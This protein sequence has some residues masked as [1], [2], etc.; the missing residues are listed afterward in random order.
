MSRASRKV[1]VLGTRHSFNDVAAIDAQVDDAAVTQ[2]Q[3]ENS[4][5][6]YISL[7]QLNA[8]VEIDS[9]RSTVTCG[10][11]ITYGE[12]C[13]RMHMEGVALHNTAS[14][15]H[16]TV[17]GACATGTHG[18]GRRQRQPFDSRCRVGAGDGRWGTAFAHD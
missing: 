10:G 18:F 17:A 4:S 14:L 5:W 8:P 3:T 11:G 15:P 12:L 9:E 7:E 1:K 6:A 16:I 13:E 2:G